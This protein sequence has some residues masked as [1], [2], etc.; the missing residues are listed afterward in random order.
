MEYIIIIVLAGICY[1]TI[2]WSKHSK[3]KKIKN[4]AL[5]GDSYAM[6]QL[7]YL[8]FF[9]IK[10]IDPALYW[11]CRAKYYGGEGGEFAN[12]LLY[13]M[14]NCGVPNFRSRYEHQTEIVHNEITK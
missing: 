11:L 13:K 12:E 9:E 2:K 14:E 4:K 10:K 3:L 7:G 6:Y 5:Q 8:Y 1:L